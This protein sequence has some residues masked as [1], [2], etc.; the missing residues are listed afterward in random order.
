MT[1]QPPASD[2][3]TDDVAAL[4]A[5]LTELITAWNAGDLDAYT[6][7]FTEDAAYITYFG[8]LLTGREEIAEGHRRVFA[9]AYRNSTLLGSP[10]RYRFL[11]PDV[12]VA[13]Q[14]G[15]VATWSDGITDEQRRST[16]SYVFVRNGGEW[17]IASFH[18]TRVSQPTE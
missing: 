13:V 14:Q 11:H 3:N 5:L 8:R 16:L 17:K 10:P 2:P 7:P 12:A 6:R 9:G 15:G 18:N 1:D 4:D